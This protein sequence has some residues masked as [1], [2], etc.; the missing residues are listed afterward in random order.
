M[1]KNEKGFALILALVLLLVMS[2][3]GGALII[4]ASSDHKNNTENDNYQQT[5]YVA[6][7]ALI[8]GQRYILNKYKGDWDNNT[9]LRETVRLL[10]TNRDDVWDGNMAEVNYTSTD[11][12]YFNTNDDEDTLCFNSF[13]DVDRSSFKIVAA[14]SWNFGEFLK[15]SNFFYEAKIPQ[16]L[17]K[18]FFE[19]FVSRVGAGP[20]KARGLSVKKKAT[21]SAATGIIYR[22]FGCGIYIENNEIQRTNK[23]LIALES[24]MILPK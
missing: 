24:T 18:Y 6:E 3:M 16:K 12:S 7:T 17:D 1:R 23:V 4:I 2:L 13:K 5:F 21:D 19:F 20:L 14:E 10:P 22:I 9:G 11:D 15:Q 8:E